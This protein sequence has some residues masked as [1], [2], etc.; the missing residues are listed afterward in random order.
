[1]ATSTVALD[2]ADD[3]AGPAAELQVEEQKTRPVSAM[4]VMSAAGEVDDHRPNRAGV[5]ALCRSLIG[6]DEAKW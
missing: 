1:M 4:T 5:A 3:H 6:G 2:Q